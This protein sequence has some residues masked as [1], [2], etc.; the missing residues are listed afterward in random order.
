MLWTETPAKEA[1]MKTG[2]TVVG[3]RAGMNV[4]LE[5]AVDGH[6]LGVADDDFCRG[7][8]EELGGASGCVLPPRLTRVN[9]AGSIYMQLHQLG[10]ACPSCQD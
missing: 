1:T 4:A 8:V 10:N 6:R 9:M 2:L 5:P 7:C 3:E